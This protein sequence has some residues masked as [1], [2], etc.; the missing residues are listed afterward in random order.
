MV[1]GE[2]AE[3]KSKLIGNHE[4]VSQARKDCIPLDTGPLGAWDPRVY[5]V[6]LPPH[7]RSGDQQEVGGMGK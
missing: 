3:D 4:L 2:G 7:A 6:P 1:Q 5:A